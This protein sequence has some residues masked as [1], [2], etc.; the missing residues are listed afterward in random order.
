MSFFQKINN[1]KFTGDWLIDGKTYSVKDDVKPILDA[2]IVSLFQMYKDNGGKLTTEQEFLARLVSLIDAEAPE[3]DETEDYVYY[4]YI[5]KEGLYTISAITESDV[6]SATTIIKEPLAAM[7]RKLNLPEACLMVIAIAADKGFN[8]L[9]DDGIGGKV[10]FNENIG[11]D[12]TGAN[13]I[14][15]TIR[16]K[17]YLIYGELVLADVTATIYVVEK[18]S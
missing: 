5:Q 2:G 14:P 11:L 8:V 7:T 1:A 3:G 16:D 9:Q 6:T 18:A 12:G 13:G 4:G 17:K 10:P 15:I